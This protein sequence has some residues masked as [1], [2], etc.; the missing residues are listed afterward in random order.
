MGQLLLHFFPQAIEKIFTH[1]HFRKIASLSLLI[2][3]WSACDSAFSTGVMAGLSR[4]DLAFTV[5]IA[6]ALYLLWAVAAVCLGILYLPRG[7]VI[8]V[9]FCVATKTPAL[10]L[11]LIAILFAGIDGVS[12]AKLAVPLVLFQCVQTAFSSLATIPLKKWHD[13]NYVSGVLEKTVADGTT[14]EME[15]ST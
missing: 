2:L 5:L 12:A 15:R 11:P 6:V 3:I 13:G 9:V 14:P 7:D 8:A 10:G 4:T 1:Y